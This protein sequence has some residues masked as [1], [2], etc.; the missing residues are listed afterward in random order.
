M[1]R[2]N[3]S[4]VSNWSF[5]LLKPASRVWHLRAPAWILHLTQF[6]ASVMTR[7]DKTAWEPTGSISVG[8]C[9]VV[10]MKEPTV[11]VG[12]KQRQICKYYTN[13]KVG[14]GP[15]ADA[16]WFSKSTWFIVKPCHPPQTRWTKRLANIKEETHP[17]PPFSHF[18][19]NIST[20]LCVG[21]VYV[22]R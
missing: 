8:A 5:S 10:D 17:H 16:R 22:Q 12:Q 11:L 20:H 21:S 6:S 19:Q 4:R 14:G 18:F 3:G 2:R 1:I 13:L 15:Q 7:Q 9:C